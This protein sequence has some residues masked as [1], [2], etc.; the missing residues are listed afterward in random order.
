[1]C[2]AKPPPSGPSSDIDGVNRE[3]RVG[4]PNGERNLGTAK[5]KQEA[6]KESKG[7]PKQT[8]QKPGGY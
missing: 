8:E 3:A 5:E 4:T 6:E 1:M 2:M 7:R